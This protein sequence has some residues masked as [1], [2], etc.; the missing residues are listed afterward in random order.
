MMPV[1]QIT[2]LNDLFFRV[3]SAGNPRAVLWQDEFSHWQPLSSHQIYQRV[4][5]LA[6]A[7]LEFGAKK[8]D[9]IALISENRWEWIVTDFAALAIGAGDVP[10]YPTLTGEQIAE[11]I[12]DAGC[13]IA[14]VST[15][16]QFD[17]LHSVRDKTQLERIVMM[18]APAPEGA[19]ALSSCSATPMRAAPSAIPSSMPWLA[20]SRRA[21]WPRSSTPQAPPASPKASPSPTATSRPTRTLRLSISASTRPTPASPSCPSRTSRPAFSIT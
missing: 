8:G 18:D 4:R 16:M 17:K 6:T 10:L 20:L 7:F 21:I 2:T 5:A 13:R 3:A 1:P 11:Q 19:I 12:R 9:R 15:R 14:V